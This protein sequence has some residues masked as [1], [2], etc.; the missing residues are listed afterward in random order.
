MP[1]DFIG[2]GW[3]FAVGTDAT[4]S[5]ALSDGPARIAQSIRIILGT[6]YGERPMRPDFGCGVHDLV[7][8]PADAR[9]AARVE[10]EVR[11]SLVRW[12]PRIEVRA[13]RAFVD[14]QRPGGLEVS[15]DYVIKHQNDPRNL[16]YPFYAIHEEPA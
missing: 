16:V 2:R 4:G 15:I 10:Q 5:I 13:V 1:H 12:E 6:S 8:A 3:A 14:D 11:A 9:L 7:F